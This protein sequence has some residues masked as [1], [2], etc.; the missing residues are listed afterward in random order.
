MNRHLER[1]VFAA[2]GRHINPLAQIFF[3]ITLFEGIAFTFFSNAHAVQTVL[4]FVLG[5]H[6]T[7]IL[8]G[9]G[10]ILLSILNVVTLVTRHFILGRTAAFM[11][12]LMWFYAVILYALGGFWIQLVIHPAAQVA[13]WIWYYFALEGYDERTSRHK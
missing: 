8:F 10:L 5:G 1:L 7:G 2:P 9:V 6:A 4:L 13:F 3:F 11:G 12:V